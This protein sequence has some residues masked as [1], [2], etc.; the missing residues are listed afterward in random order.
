MMFYDMLGGQGFAG[1][2][3]RYQDSCDLSRLLDL[4]LAIVVAHVDGAGSQLVE[5]SGGLLAGSDDPSTIVY[6]VVFLV[7]SESRTLN[8]EP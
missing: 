7:P 5:K 6:R 2:P 1:L 4:G 3:N 8:P